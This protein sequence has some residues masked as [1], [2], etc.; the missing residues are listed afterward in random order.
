LQLRRPSSEDLLQQ[1]AYHDVDS[2]CSLE[3]QYW[4]LRV[5]LSFYDRTTEAMARGIALSRILKLPVKAEIGRM[6]ELSDW[7]RFGDLL[8]TLTA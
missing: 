6:K 2:F 5:I 8:T 1:S 7:N 4:M 3:K